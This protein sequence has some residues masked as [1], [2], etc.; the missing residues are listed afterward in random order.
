M[1]DIRDV[2]DAVVAILETNQAAIL[3]VCKA[4]GANRPL[5]IINYFSANIDID[6]Y[7]LIMVAMDSEGD[8]WMSMP[9][10]DESAYNLTIWGLVHHDVP[11]EREVIIGR[12]AGAVKLALN[13]RHEPTTL[14]DG[15]Q[16]YFN[17]IMPIRQ[18]LYGINSFGDGFVSAFAAYFRAN[19]STSVPDDRDTPP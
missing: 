14:A 11:Q 15:S 6:Q 1:P 10:T 7:N 5:T 4:A 8:E 9:V 13:H 12:F 16:M 3:A 19:V 18:I 2:V 17:D